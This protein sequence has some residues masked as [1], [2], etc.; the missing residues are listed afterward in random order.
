MAELDEIQINEDLGQVEYEITRQDVER[1]LASVGPYEYEGRA[2]T[3]APCAP[4]IMIGNDYLKLYKKKYSTVGAL[5]ARLEM[6]VFRCLPCGQTVVTRG[7]IIDKYTKRGK[8]SVVI[9][10]STFNQQS[11][12]IVNFTITLTYV[13]F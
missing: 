12:A 1:F 10:T 4:P 13:V 8:T 2:E 3:G 6:E 5:H 9:L 7:K 11:E